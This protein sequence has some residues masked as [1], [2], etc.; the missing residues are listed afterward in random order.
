MYAPMPTQSVF[1]YRS[2][3]RFLIDFAESKQR[4]DAGFSIRKWAREMGVSHALIVMLLQGKRSL[5][6]K[7]VPFLAKGMGLSSPEKLYL[8]AL[9]QFEN[10]DSDEERELCELWL[11]EVNPGTDYKIREVDEY[12]VIA[13]WVHMAILAMTNLASFSG[14]PEEIYL[15]LGKKVSLFEIRAAVERLKAL[16]ILEEKDGRL[17]CTYHRITTRD[18]VAN[19]GAREYHKQIAALIPEAIETQ[20]VEQREFQSFAV[21]VPRSKIPL[22]KELIR[23]FRTQ[24]YEAMTSEPGDEVYQTSIQFFRLTESPSEIVPKED[25]GAGA[26]FNAPNRRSNHV[27]NQ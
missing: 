16:N 23:K 14:V 1:Q 13:H 27:Q 4:T 19:R 24:F 26:E 8:Q 7:Q 20:P 5:T 6:L 15:R 22:A 25:A 11:S 9:I 18:D 17:H 3:K 2:A 21:S 12:L 10:A